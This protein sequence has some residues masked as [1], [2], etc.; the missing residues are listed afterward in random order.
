MLVP[1]FGVSVAYIHFLILN[2]L[3]T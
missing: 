3:L 2:Y 1:Q